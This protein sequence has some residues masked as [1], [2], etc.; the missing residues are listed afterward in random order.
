MAAL[1][2]PPE[3]PQPGLLLAR[4]ISF[5][6]MRSAADLR[7]HFFFRYAFSDGQQDYL[8]GNGDWQRYRD[9]AVDV[10]DGKLD[11]TATRTGGWRPGDFT[12]G[13]V[14]TRFAQRRG[15]IEACV[16]FPRGQGLWS[17]I[18]LMSEDA[19]WPPSITLASAANKDGPETRFTY[20]E[21]TSPSVGPPQ[22]S[23]LDRW[24]GL[25]W[26]QPVSDRFHVFAVDWT[27]DAITHYADG[28]AL[29]TR[30]F[31]WR[32]GNGME[33]APAQLVINLAVGGSASG[34]PVRAADFPASLEIAW[35]RFWA[36]GPET[37]ARAP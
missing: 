24:D 12:S 7:N 23:S 18:S 1:V 8:P 35:I 25:A 27:A 2:P 5:A 14:R 11:L 36:H 3:P 31:A 22:S 19:G 17:S 4:E 30:P 32:H 20:H 29:A 21:A 28:R 33:A 26:D 15:Y 10:R 9:D 6:G 16:R 37:I 13:L 34:P